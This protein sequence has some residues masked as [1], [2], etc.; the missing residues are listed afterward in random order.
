[1][2]KIVF[3]LVLS[4]I[5]NGI[6][7]QKKKTSTSSVLAK[8]DNVTAQI[9]TDKKVKKLV[10][11][12]KN[13]MGVDTLEVKK[14]IKSDFKPLNFSLSSITIDG[15]KLY[16]LSWKENIVTTTKMKYEAIDITE[17]QIW[18]TTTKSLLMG[19]TQKATHLKETQYLDKGKTATQDVERKRNEGFEFILMPNGDL[20]LKT[21]TQ[22][23]HYKYN[24][25]TDKFESS[26][27]VVAKSSSS[28]KRR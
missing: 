12:V 21:K 24:K 28:K 5:S 20:T 1:M 15:V 6:F 27:V 16:A 9:I 18:N 22:E 19:N 14:D 25:A 4:L 17:S 3:L 23:N 7:S 13:E 26:K 10:L 8:V 2:K 11:F